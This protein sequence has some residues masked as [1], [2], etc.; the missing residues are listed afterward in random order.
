MKRT[1][2]HEYH[3]TRNTRIIQQQELRRTRRL[4]LLH[5]LRTNTV[6]AH[7]SLP[8]YENIKNGILSLNL[9]VVY[10]SVYQF[11]QIL[12]RTEAPPIQEMVQTH[13]VP[14]FVEL[15]SLN[16]ILY[17]DAKEKALINSCRTEAAWVLTNIASG[18]TQQTSTIIENGGI[19]LLFKMLNEND[20]I[21]DQA[22]W[23]L[24]NIA[25]DKEVFRDNILHFPKSLEL[26]FDLYKRNN[27]NLTK[28]VTWLLSNL[29]RGKNPVIE[30]KKA[31]II[32]KVFTN[33]LKSNDTDVVHDV[34]W[35][36]SYIIDG[37]FK[38]IDKELITYLYSLLT[39]LCDLKGTEST[40]VPRNLTAPLIRCI[41]NA[42]VVSDDVMTFLM[43]NSLL[44]VLKSLFFK[45]S[46]PKLRRE[47]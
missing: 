8:N 3:N 15:L 40:N 25:G 6:A 22:I 17:T 31:A 10:D 2:M 38:V 5:K 20:D 23:C 9:R 43:S 30:H 37:N 13:L 47:I 26:L 12:C 11:R 27:A 42:C 18:D 44:G 14:R 45:I 36:I 7:S 4:E 1:Y 35:G 33:L 28:N 24:S 46:A 34:I 21:A 16:N 32:I 19:P 41:G 29:C 39:Q